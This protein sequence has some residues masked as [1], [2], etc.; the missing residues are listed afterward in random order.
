MATIHLSDSIGEDLT[1]YPKSKIKVLLLENIESSGRDIFLKADFQVELLPKSLPAAELKEKIKDIHLLG[2][3]SKTKITQDVLDCAKKLKAIGCF[4]IG[5]D[6]VDLVAAEIRGIPVFNSPFANTRSVA[7]LVLAEIVMLARTAGD[8]S[9]ELHQGVWKKTHVNC[10][11]IRGK[12]LGIVGYG[13]VGS[14]VSTLA[15]SFGMR[16]QFFDISRKLPLGNAKPVDSLETLLKTSDFVTLHVPKTPLTN[17]MIT[18]TQLEL[19]QPG[20]YLLNLSRGDVVDVNDLAEALKSGH[21]RGA[22]V[23]VFPQEPESNGPGFITPLQ[24]CPNTILT[25]H[26]GGSTQE[27]QESIGVEVA[28]KLTTFLVEGA[29]DGAVNFPNLTPHSYPGTHRLL[30]IHKNQPGVLRAINDIL[31]IYNVS[32]QLLATTKNIGYMIIDLDSAMSTEVFK[33]LRTLEVSIKTRI[34]Y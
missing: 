33:K 31:S 26:I 32:G 11:E 5:T 16:V 23:D 7:E 25:P 22:A 19:M 13:H 34:L 10:H 2:I 3:R 8:R 30:H 24:G 4:C 20:T 14:Q 18:K 12:L 9:M 28:A 6:Q 15:E 21:L 29:T 27:A 17:R 1:I